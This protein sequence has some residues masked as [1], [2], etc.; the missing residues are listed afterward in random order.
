MSCFLG[1]G[2]AIRKPARAFAG[3]AFMMGAEARVVSPLPQPI[4]QNA[5]DKDPCS[6]ARV[7]SSVHPPL[8]GSLMLPFRGGRNNFAPAALGPSWAIISNCATRG[9]YDGPF[10]IK[11]T[12]LLAAVFA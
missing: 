10:L 12:P 2:G 9:W 8:P 11:K 5:R 6:G 4:T 7:F 1:R 3:R